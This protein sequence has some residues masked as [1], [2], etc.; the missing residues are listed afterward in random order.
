[1]TWYFYLNYR[2]YNF[3]QKRDDIPVF[4]AFLVTSTLATLNLITF[5]GM[6]GFFLPFFKQLT[7]V[8]LVLISYALIALINYLIVY[9]KSFYEEV[10]N[11]FDRQPL[12]LKSWD[13]SVKLYIGT[14]IGLLLLV[15]IIADMKNQGYL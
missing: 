15:L 4:Y 8:K 3:Y 6:T 5:V 9:K 1:M 11:E 14:S 12:K 2:I 13:K 7:N 10:F